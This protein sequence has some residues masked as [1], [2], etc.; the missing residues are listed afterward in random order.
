MVVVGFNCAL[1]PHPDRPH[2]RSRLA[3]VDAQ[4]GRVIKG[5]EAP[6]FVSGVLPTLWHSRLETQFF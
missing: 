1:G 5:H 6:S 2:L 3:G 4:R